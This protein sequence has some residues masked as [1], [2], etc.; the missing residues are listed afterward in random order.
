MNKDIWKNFDTLPTETELEDLKGFNYKT[1]ELIDILS[2][3]NYK[4]RKR[5][6][7][8]SEGVL[9]LMGYHNLLTKNLVN[10]QE[11]I[12]SWLIKHRGINLFDIIEN[13]I[14]RESEIHYTMSYISVN[15]IKYLK[16]NAGTRQLKNECIESINK[17][18]EKENCFGLGA[19]KEYL[20]FLNLALSIKNDEDS[21]KMIS[22]LIRERKFKLPFLEYAVKEEVQSKINK[23]FKHLDFLNSDSYPEIH[24]FFNTF[25]DEKNNN[26]VCVKLS[27]ISCLKVLLD[28][29]NLTFK[30]EI[31]KTKADSYLMG[32]NS[33]LNVILTE[34]DRD[35]L[36]IKSIIKDDR[37]PKEFLFEY[38]V[39]DEKEVRFV[40][41]EIFKHFEDSIEKKVPSMMDAFKGDFLDNLLIKVKHNQLEKMIVEHVESTNRKKMKV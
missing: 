27:P 34:D 37:R 30:H 20:G 6:G 16:D 9:H 31:T 40:I 3:Y 19:R 24:K 10:S 22:L 23:R 36:K 26:N 5:F 2:E 39:K 35:K 33:F 28:M 1:K 18:L 17:G 4:G 41:E 7:S 8:L 13:Q 25:R 15:A 14:L 12:N 29:E 38:D 21:L 32:F 11:E